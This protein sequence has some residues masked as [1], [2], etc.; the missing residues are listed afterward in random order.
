M[1]YKHTELSTRHWEGVSDTSM[2]WVFAMVINGMR[3]KHTELSTRHWEGV[4]DTSKVWVV[5]VVINWC[6]NVDFLIG[7]SLVLQDY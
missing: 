3:Y 1:R 6:T 2:V 7:N 5:V 4:S